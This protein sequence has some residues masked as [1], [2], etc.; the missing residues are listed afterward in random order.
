MS[1]LLALVL[2]LLAQAWP[3]HV[4]YDHGVWSIDHRPVACAV[5]EDAPATDC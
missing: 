3:G 4:G 2:S 5:T 1:V